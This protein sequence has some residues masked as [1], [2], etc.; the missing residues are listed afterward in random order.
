MQLKGVAISS[1]EVQLQ[2]ARGTILMHEILLLQ[3][4]ISSSH[5]RFPHPSP[6][7]PVLSPQLLALTC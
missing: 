2:I 6:A 3:F 1:E 4:V 5:H 7:R